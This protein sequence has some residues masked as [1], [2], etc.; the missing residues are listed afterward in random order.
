MADRIGIP[1]TNAGPANA[2]SRPPRDAGAP[3]AHADRQGQPLA[4][5]RVLE[6]TATLAIPSITADGDAGSD[7]STR[8]AGNFERLSIRMRSEIRIAIPCHRSADTRHF[9]RVRRAG[10]LNETRFRNLAR[11]R[12]AISNRGA[13]HNTERPHSALG[14]KT[15]PNM[16]DP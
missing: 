15:R 13:D 5:P 1:N 6:D 10:L 7:E 4:A 14:Y 11:A 2:F 3:D 16:H 8:I 12:N 9:R